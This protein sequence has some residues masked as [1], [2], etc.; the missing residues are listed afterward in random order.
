LFK[1]LVEVWHVG[2]EISGLIIGQQL[3]TFESV[4]GLGVEILSFS[5]D[6]ALLVMDVAF[7]FRLEFGV[8]FALD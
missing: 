3:F 1:V 4:E 2:I 6:G 5:F 8:Y 7:D